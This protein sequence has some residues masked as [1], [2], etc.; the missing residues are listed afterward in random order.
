MIGT[1]RRVDIVMR[2]IVVPFDVVEVHRLRDLWQLIQTL[3]ECL[4][5]RIV[6]RIEGCPIRD[7]DA[8]ATFQK[9]HG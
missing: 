6:P 2:I 1:R 9:E 8:T 7:F 4:E 5:R 3:E